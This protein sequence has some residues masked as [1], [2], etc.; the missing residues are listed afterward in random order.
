MSKCDCN[1]NLILPY[2]KLKK[3]IYLESWLFIILISYYINVFSILTQ[4][5]N[6]YSSVMAFAEGEQAI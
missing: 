1:F 3:N 2:I 5:H 6:Q 4:K